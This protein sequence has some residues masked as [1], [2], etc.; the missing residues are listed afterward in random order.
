MSRDA[1]KVFQMIDDLCQKHGVQGETNPGHIYMCDM[2]LVRFYAQPIINILRTRI[3]SMKHKETKHFT[4]EY[5]VSAIVNMLRNNTS[6]IR[7]GAVIPDW[8]PRDTDEAVRSFA[9]I[10]SRYLL[11]DYGY[12]DMVMIQRIVNVYTYD[13]IVKAC[14]VGSSNRVYEVRYISAV[15]E[16]ERAK[17]QVRVN[18]MQVIENRA[19][20]SNRLLDRPIHTHTIMDIASMEYTWSQKRENA[21]I[22]REFDEMARRLGK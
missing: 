18:K 1:R 6:A 2:L 8:L 21:R 10:V 7:Q 12:D 13:E 22:E 5:W 20:E 3:N 11:V 14:I 17:E 19:A 15:L 16:K 9:H 4:F